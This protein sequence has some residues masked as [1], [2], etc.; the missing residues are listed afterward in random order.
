V[1][2]PGQSSLGP[3]YPLDERGRTE[4][5]G[6]AGP[7]RGRTGTGKRHDAGIESARAAVRLEPPPVTSTAPRATPRALASSAWDRRT[8]SIPPGRQRHATTSSTAR[9][10]AA[11]AR[12]E[13][14]SRG[15]PLHVPAASTRQGCDRPS[16]RCCFSTAIQDRQPPQ[17]EA[18]RRR[19]I[20]TGRRHST[21]GST[22]LHHAYPRM[23][24]ATG[25]VGGTMPPP[26]ASDRATRQTSRCARVPSG[27][28]RAGGTARP[29]FGLYDR[30]DG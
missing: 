16:G 20:A 28:H 19:T 7:V 21:C 12:G 26:L 13:A 24:V 27:S 10:S 25:V 1:A 9:T 18:R 5:R 2:S 30:V 8:P 4:A 23:A 22:T 11:S 6:S 29:V 14:H 3:T 15:P 17:S